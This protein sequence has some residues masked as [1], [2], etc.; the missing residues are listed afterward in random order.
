MTFIPD[1]LKPSIRC[2]PS[3]GLSF[4]Q[5][6]ETKHVPVKYE[7]SALPSMNASCVSSSFPLMSYAM[8]ASSFILVATPVLAVC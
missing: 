5:S 1:V 3:N 8:N 6:H 7:P 4:L 2:C